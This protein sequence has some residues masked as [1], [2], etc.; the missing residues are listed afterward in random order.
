MG[1]VQ[2]KLE[3]RANEII[4]LRKEL[5][6]MTPES[7]FYKQIFGEETKDAEINMNKFTVSGDSFGGITAIE[8]AQNLTSTEC[9]ACLTMDPWMAP[10]VNEFDSEESEFFSTFDVDVQVLVTSNFYFD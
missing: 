3:I 6:A 2:E 5:A 10:R 8:V 9:H 1:P 4:E 7:N